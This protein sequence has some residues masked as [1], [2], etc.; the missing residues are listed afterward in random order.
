MTG[1]SMVVLLI[2]Y[3]KPLMLLALIGSIVGLSQFN[4]GKPLLVASSLRRGR[5]GRAEAKR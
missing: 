3:F 4:C 2:E 5:Q 1:T